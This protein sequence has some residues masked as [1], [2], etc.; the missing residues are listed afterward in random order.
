M[1]EPTKDMTLDDAANAVGQM[2]NFFKAFRRVSDLVQFLRGA[3][4]R[5]KE[6]ATEIEALE[7][8]RLAALAAAKA[9]TEEADGEFKA[10]TRKL[11]KTRET[12]EQIEAEA[13][14]KTAEAEAKVAGIEA[15]GEGLRRAAGEAID[16]ALARKDEIEAEAAVAED[17]LARA[18]ETL[19]AIAAAATGD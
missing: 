2:E 3:E 18:R 15:E 16:A 1:T 14:R 19:A 17:R 13:E 12:V 4:Q 11:K 5:K 7:A 8:R 10:L 9:Q 6:M